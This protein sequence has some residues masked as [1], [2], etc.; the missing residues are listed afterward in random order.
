MKIQDIDYISKSKTKYHF[1]I[2]YLVKETFHNLLGD[3]EIAS[4]SMSLM[5]Y[6]L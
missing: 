2:L 3:V 4:T 6:S 5:H 1:I